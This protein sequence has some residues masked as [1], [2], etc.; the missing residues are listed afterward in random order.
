MR[1]VATEPPA[2]KT[3][4]GLAGGSPVP[5]AQTR[6][7]E[8]K[9]QLIVFG[10]LSSIVLELSQL[11]AAIFLRSSRDDQHLMMTSMTIL[12]TPVNHL[13]LLAD[14]VSDAP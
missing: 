3:T 14:V 12:F 7:F 8:Q 6:P 4:G 2:R 10:L 13:F 11:I 9:I 5:S 1:P